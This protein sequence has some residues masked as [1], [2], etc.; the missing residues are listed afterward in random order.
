MQTITLAIFLVVNG[1]MQTIRIKQPD[2]DTCQAAAKQ[3][4]PALHAVHAECLVREKKEK[5]QKA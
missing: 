5:K 4:A 3:I 1:H 2:L